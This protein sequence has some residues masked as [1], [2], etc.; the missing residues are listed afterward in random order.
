M[1]DGNRT[2]G[3]AGATLHMLSFDVE[4]YFHVEAAALAPALWNSY[5]SRVE[6]AVER[7][8][9]L[10]EEH[11]AHATFFVLG[12]VACRHR[13]LVRALSRGG[14]E[15]ASHGTGH[16]MLNRLD[17]KRFRGDLRTSR[18]ILED[19]TGCRVVGYR[20]DILDHSPDGMGPG[21][22]G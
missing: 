1:S 14:H 5:P 13:R 20:T 22:A 10:L 9:E 15:I 11:E 21:R 19:L 12:W 6:A 17:P 3:R 2:I 4:E 7:I 18:G 8:L 16:V